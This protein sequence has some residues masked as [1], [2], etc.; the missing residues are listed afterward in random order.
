MTQ[1][2]HAFFLQS[3]ARDMCLRIIFVFCRTNRIT[4]PVSKTVAV[5]TTSYEYLLLYR[6]SFRSRFSLLRGHCRSMISVV[7][8][9]LRERRQTTTAIPLFLPELCVCLTDGGEPFV[10]GL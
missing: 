3:T 8:R 9:K 1:D 4:R 10:H 6:P 5:K 7:N 2:N